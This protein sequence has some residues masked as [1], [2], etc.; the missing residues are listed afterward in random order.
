M[1]GISLTKFH[2]KTDCLKS[3]ASRTVEVLHGC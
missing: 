3:E 2:I 1:A